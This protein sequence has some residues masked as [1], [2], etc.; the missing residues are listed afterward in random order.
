MFASR[1]PGPRRPCGRLQRPPRDGSG[2]GERPWRDGR[3]RR[4]RVSG[5]DLYR[6]AR[7]G[8]C[9]LLQLEGLA[10]VVV[11]DV[12]A[13]AAGQ[14]GIHAGCGGEHRGER[15]D[16]A[17]VGVP[18]GLVL[19]EDVVDRYP[20]LSGEVRRGARPLADDLEQFLERA[21]GRGDLG[22]VD[23]EIGRASCRER[24]LVAV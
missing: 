24:V 20:D 12:V 8:E 19:G 1:E 11:V 18:E 23:G 17:L 4:D 5:R 9:E 21:G 22:A 15:V 7:Q 3:R 16:P 13:D 6:G 10:E 2:E 14:G